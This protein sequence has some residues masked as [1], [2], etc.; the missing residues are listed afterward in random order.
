VPFTAPERERFTSLLI[1]KGWSLENEILWSPSRGLHF[2]ESHFVDWSPKEM[3][4]VF[5]RRGDRIQK[6]A[7]AGRD[8]FAGEHRDVCS[9]AEEVIRA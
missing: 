1:G 5:T 4:D 9:A 6:S 2:N 3:R 8:R 7:L